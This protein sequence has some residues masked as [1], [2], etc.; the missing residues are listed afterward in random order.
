MQTSACKV[1]STQVRGVQDGVGEF[2]MLKVGSAQVRM[3]Q[4][5]VTKICFCQAHFSHIGV[6]E[7]GI[8]QAGT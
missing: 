1:C 7:I 3:F 6:P 5:R 8:I 4:V 2:C